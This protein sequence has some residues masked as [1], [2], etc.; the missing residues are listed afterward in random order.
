M[1]AHPAS[2]WEEIQQRLKG[3]SFYAE[4][5]YDGERAQVSYLKTIQSKFLQSIVILCQTPV[6]TLQC[7]WNRI[8]IHMLDKM[9]CKI[10]LH[11][12]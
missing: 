10:R 6:F 7:V 1:L 9:Y 4:Y 8:S 3:S 12:N 2:T 5:K 11:L